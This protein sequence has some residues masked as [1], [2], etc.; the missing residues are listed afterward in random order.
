M[1]LRAE[2]SDGVGVFVVGTALNQRV[3][4]DPRPDG[5]GDEFHCHGARCQ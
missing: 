5:F 1:K 3:G 2:Q 4:S